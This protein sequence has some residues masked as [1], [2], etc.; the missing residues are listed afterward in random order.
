MARVSCVVGAFCLGLA[1]TSFYKP[2]TVEAETSSEDIDPACV[3]AIRVLGPALAQN[4]WI[5]TPMAKETGVGDQQ[6]EPFFNHIIEAFFKTL[7]EETRPALLQSIS[8]TAQ[9]VA[10]TASF[11]LAAGTLEEL[12]AALTLKHTA[13]AALTTP[14]ASPGESEGE[15]LGGPGTRSLSYTEWDEFVMREEGDRE[16]KWSDVTP[17]LRAEFQDEIANLRQTATDWGRYVWQSCR[18]EW[19]KFWYFLDW[20][21]SGDD[22]SAGGNESPVS[23]FI[24]RVN[25]KVDGVLDAFRECIPEGVGAKVSGDY[26]SLVY[27]VDIAPK[28]SCEAYF[29][30]DVDDPGNQQYGGGLHAGSGVNQ[31]GGVW[32]AD[33]KFD[34]ANNGRA[35]VTFNFRLSI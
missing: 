35:A 21:R 12:C 7:D 23:Q 2:E 31:N 30:V 13:S 17:Y 3:E 26:A 16:P 1:L 18:C 29:G 14:P 15:A 33:L 34:G 22:S 19:N 24:M 6:S 32:S 28:L 4:L 25:Q 11:T 9:I 10:D 20:S 8:V 27:Q 5:E